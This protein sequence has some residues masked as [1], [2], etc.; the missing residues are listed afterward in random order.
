MDGD[1]AASIN[2]LN[3][4]DRR[5]PVK[6]ARHVVFRG[7]VQGVGFRAFVEEAAIRQGL[8]GWVR[9]RSVGTVEVVFSGDAAAVDAVVETCRKGPRLSRVESID[10]RE[11]NGDELKLRGSETFAV[12]PTV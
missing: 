8:Q 11:A 2:A 3:R 9:N 5:A 6:V 10:Q 4:R 7:R 12:L 1:A